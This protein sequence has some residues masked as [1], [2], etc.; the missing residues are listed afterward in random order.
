MTLQNKRRLWTGVAFA[1]VTIA[2]G[3]AFAQQGQRGISSYAP[4]TIV[5]PFSAILE[6][7]SAQKPCCW[8]VFSPGVGDLG[9]GAARS[10]GRAVELAQSAPSSAE[11]CEGKEGRSRRAQ[12][13]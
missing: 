7:L 13:H 3:S 6:R 5:E 1:A 9:H 12:Y 10:Y 8:R 11:P 4:V 2:L